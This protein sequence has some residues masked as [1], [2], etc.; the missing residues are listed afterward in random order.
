MLL[1]NGLIVITCVFV[2]VYFFW[3]AS[4]LQSRLKRARVIDDARYFELKAKNEFLV[5]CFA[6]FVA[7]VGFLGYSSIKDL[8]IS[9]RNELTMR[10]DSALIKLD[11]LK[12]DANT[13][14]DITAGMAT[15]ILDVEERQRKLNVM[16]SASFADVEKLRINVS[17]IAESDVLKRDFYLID[18]ITFD[19]KEAAELPTKRLY[20]RDM[21]TTKGGGLPSI[22]SVPFIL[23]SASNGGKA[24][25][26][27]TTNE[28]VDLQLSVVSYPGGSKDPES[29]K[30]EKY[31]IRLIIYY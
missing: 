10:V 19:F 27:N 21:V 14:A 2:L 3:N 22:T 30:N 24:N 26:I 18:N 20:Y 15:R 6:M 23:V 31:N 4:I 25:I 28:Y 9:L 29:L 11:S 17:E 7:L 5:A 1:L 16:T 13:T 12:K 8:E